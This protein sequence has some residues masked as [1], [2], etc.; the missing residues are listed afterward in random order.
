MDTRSK[1]LTPDRLEALVGAGAWTV[2]AGTF[3]PMTAG[4]AQRLAAAV[5][6]EKRLAVIVESAAHDFL[7]M[8]EARAILVAAL[9]G[10][11]AV[12]IME[13]APAF[14]GGVAVL[15]DDEA[16]HARTQAFVELM[17]QKQAR[18]PR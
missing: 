6:A 13:S 2:L 14:V 17:L 4:Q 18:A 11:D 3:D 10:V 7:L 16:E 1:I 12:V 5:K 8:P 9:R 15:K